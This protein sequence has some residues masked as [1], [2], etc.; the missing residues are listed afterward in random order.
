MMAELQKKHTL[1]ILPAES[2]L[3]TDM[4]D[5]SLAWCYVSLAKAMSR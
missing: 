1:K 4:T 5:V 2:N 3:V